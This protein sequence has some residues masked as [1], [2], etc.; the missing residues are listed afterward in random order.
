[1]RDRS[2]AAARTLTFLRTSGR[3]VLF[4]ALAFL[5]FLGAALLDVEPTIARYSGG[6]SMPRLLGW[7]A[8]QGAI[9]LLAS[10]VPLRLLDDLPL[11]GLGLGRPGAL[12][13]SA[14]GVLLGAACLALP[15]AL[16]WGLGVVAAT[17]LAPPGAEFLAWAAGAVLVNA[18]MQEVA[19][20][21][22]PWLLL[23]RTLGPAWALGITAALFAWWHAD[24][25]AGSALAA[26]NLFGFG[27]LFGALRWRSGALWLPV[28]AH[29]AWNVPARAGPRPHGERERPPRPAVGRAAA[30]RRARPPHRGGLR[31]RGEPGRL[32]HR[33]PALAATLRWRP[34]ASPAPR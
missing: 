11:A 23:D 1:M 30:P 12:R 8:V 14:R 19:F 21:G 33:S 25:M 24:A 31:A 6:R 3:L 34:T 18:F 20:H 7:A 5:L 13:D 10:W 28:A 29:A 15:L 22:Y 27:L 2:A 4:V 32:A 17:G 26:A 9:V 16:L